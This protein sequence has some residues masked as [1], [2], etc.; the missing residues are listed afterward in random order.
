M[1]FK[2]YFSILPQTRAANDKLSRRFLSDI[3]LYEGFGEIN[4]ADIVTDAGGKPRFKDGRFFFNLSHSKNYIVCAVSDREAGADV[5]QIR[6]ALIKAAAKIL[7]DQEKETAKKLSGEEKFR[8]LLNRWVLAEAYVK[9]TG[10]GVNRF[11]KGLPQITE[12]NKT[13]YLAENGVYLH[14][15][16]KEHCSVCAASPYKT[17]PQWIEIEIL[18]AENG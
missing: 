7:K 18:P 4:D 9:Y 13:L 11:F 3:S 1:V 15:F 14:L 12:L 17:P 2:L 5:E 10:E 6:G 16:E 8:Y